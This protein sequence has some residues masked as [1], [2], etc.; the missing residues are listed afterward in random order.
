[1]KTPDCEL[2]VPISLICCRVKLRSKVDMPPAGEDLVIDAVISPYSATPE[3]V[4]LVYTVMYG[5]EVHFPMSTTGQSGMV[6]NCRS[7][8]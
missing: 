6:F 8:Q 3:C 1:M 5:T 7:W 4:S 2:I